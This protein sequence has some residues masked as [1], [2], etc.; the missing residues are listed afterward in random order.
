MNMQNVMQK[1]FHRSWLLIGEAATGKSMFGLTMTPPLIYIDTDGRLEDTVKTWI[2]AAEDEQEKQRRYDVAA[3]LH[4]INVGHDLQ[5]IYAELD[6]VPPQGGTIVM[7]NMSNVFQEMVEESMRDKERRKEQGR[8]A[9]VDIWGSKARKMKELRN[10]LLSYNTE[11]LWI[12]HW[13]E[14]IRDKHGNVVVKD[15]T[16]LSGRELQK[17]TPATNLWLHMALDPSGKRMITPTWFRGG[18]PPAP[19]PDMFG[20][21]TGTAEAIDRVLLQSAQQSFTSAQATS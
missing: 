12:L 7:D 17:F 14:G 5:A 16:S 18:P 3:G 2:W 20:F 13:Q 6:R 15:R 1:P 8:K 19:L 9:G 10:R 4:H 21:W 11:I